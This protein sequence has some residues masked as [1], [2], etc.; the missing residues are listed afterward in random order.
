MRLNLE[1]QPRDAMTK[2]QVKRLRKE[3]NTL[4]SLSEAGKETKHFTVDEKSLRD[5]LRRG[6]PSAMVELK[7][8]SGR[9]ALSMPRQVQRDPVTHKILSIGMVALSARKPI[10]A[11][12]PVILH[13]EP[14]PVK[15]GIG[16]LDQENQTVEVKALPDKLPANLVIDVSGLELHGKVQ[17]SD[18][19]TNPDYEIVTAADT[20]IAV[21]H[22]VRAAVTEEG[23]AEEEVTPDEEKQAEVEAG[24]EE[25]AS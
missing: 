6:G 7:T 9:P 3:G 11:P 14:A 22:T 17:V 16:V 24:E 18:I 1:A 10:T 12:V 19:P 8:G 2:G 23:T 25:A 4:L 20:M 5:L 15:E 13:G 21:V